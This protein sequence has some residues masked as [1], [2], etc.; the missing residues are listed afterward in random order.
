MK[1]CRT[2]AIINLDDNLSRMQ[3][4]GHRGSGIAI[5]AGQIDD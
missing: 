1:A 4:Y 5:G 3:Q 2:A